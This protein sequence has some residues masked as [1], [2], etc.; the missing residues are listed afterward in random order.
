VFLIGRASPGPQSD[1]V[2][3]LLMGGELERYA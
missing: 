3:G 2:I 1:L